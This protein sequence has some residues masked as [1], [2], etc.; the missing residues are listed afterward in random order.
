M[1]TLALV[2]ICL[3]AAPA[4]LADGVAQPASQLGVGTLSPDGSIRYIAAPAGQETALLAIS[5]KTGSVER[6]TD[7]VGVYGLPV[8]TF[9]A[10]SYEGLSHDGRTLVLSDTQQ[11][12]TSHFVLY[13]TRSLQMKDAF[14]LKGTFAYDALSPDA[15]RLYLIQRP[16]VDD[17]QRY[18]VRAYDLRTKRLLPGRIAD[19]TQR[20]WVM[21]GSAMTRTTSADGRWVY[22]L[23][24]NPGGY[25]FVHALDTVRG[26]AHCVGLPATQS[27]QNALGNI[28][29]SLHG[30]RLSVH[31]RS[32]RPWLDVDLSTWRVTPATDGGLPWLWLGLGI[33]AAVGVGVGLRA[34]RPKGT[35]FARPA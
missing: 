32:G 24:Y 12:P 30:K 31:W 6:A 20:S 23:Y 28:V 15:S 7:L 22:T 33:A 10:R 25:P 8:L 4:A 26:V 2:L 3:A 1:K 18:V 11:S 34:L 17:Y 16:L 19:R 27:E 21:Q 13:D 5:T 35:L 29:L 9:N 14:F